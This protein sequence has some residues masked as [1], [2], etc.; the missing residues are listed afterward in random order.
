MRA[1]EARAPGHQDPCELSDS[2]HRRSAASRDGESRSEARYA[3]TASRQLRIV[4]PRASAFEQSSTDRAGRGRIGR[5]SSSVR[6]RSILEIL[7]ARLVQAGASELPPARHTR[8]WPRGI[9]RSLRAPTAG[10]SSLAEVVGVGRAP[11]WSSTTRIGPLARPARR[12]SALGEYRR[13]E[14][15]AASEDPAGSHDQEVGR[16]AARTRSSPSSL[17]RP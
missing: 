7:V 4:T 16:A 2:T 15:A 9:D 5:S 10:E 17:V 8:D 3:L 13:D 6:M 1:D 11:C 14:V 12:S